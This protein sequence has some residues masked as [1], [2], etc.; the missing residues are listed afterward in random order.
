MRNVR[1]IR[2]VDLKRFEIA[3]TPLAGVVIIHFKIDPKCNVIH[4]SCLGGHICAG[5][6]AH[7]RSTSVRYAAIT[8]ENQTH[9][10]I[11]SLVSPLNIK[12]NKS[13]VFFFCFNGFMEPHKIIHMT[14]YLVPI[15]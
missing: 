5:V 8:E 2:A 14:P 7:G 9:A 11:T 10:D 15:K 3:N 12:I 1:I 13:F 6:P 4:L